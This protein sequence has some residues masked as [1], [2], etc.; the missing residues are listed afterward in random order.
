MNIA[1][2]EK[3]ILLDFIVTH[4]LI[5]TTWLNTLRDNFDNSSEALLFKHTIYKYYS[6]ISAYQTLIGDVFTEPALPLVQMIYRRFMTQNVNNVDDFLQILDT[7]DPEAFKL[8]VVKYAFNKNTIL[9]NNTFLE[10]LSLLDIGNETKFVLFSAYRNFGVYR[11]KLKNCF[12][13]LYPIFL[14]HYIEAEKL[15]EPQLTKFY[16]EVDKNTNSYFLNI[17]G[18]EKL[19]TL[20]RKYINNKAKV[21]LQD[22]YESEIVPLM[23]SAN[24]LVIISGEPFTTNNDLFQPV[25]CLGL[26]TRESATQL[27][28]A[29][30][31]RKSLLKALGDD[32]R[33]E[34]LRMIH[35]GFN[36]NK[37]LSDFF[38][39]SPPAITYQTNI[40]KQAGLVDSYGNGLLCVNFEKIK[41]GL[42]SIEFLFLLVGE[43]DNEDNT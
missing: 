6:D 39:I 7:I 33:F 4:E 15:F 35:Y 34:I 10:N 27:K 26:L 2:R 36:T 8:A 9:D 20:Y 11:K 32:T 41:L 22:N 37:K 13:T 21:L 43:T 1:K 28:N 12:S 14:Q 23:F 25:I 17:L 30:N 31:I 3:C 18:T 5:K 38:Q 16:K 29:D 40:L 42:K 24:R 19:D